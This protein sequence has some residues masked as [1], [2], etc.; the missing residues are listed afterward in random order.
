MNPG[1]DRHVIKGGAW[2][3]T[4]AMTRSAF[5]LQGTADTTDMRVG[6]RVARD[7]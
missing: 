6:F 1:C 4:P 2:S 5:R 7:L 3:S